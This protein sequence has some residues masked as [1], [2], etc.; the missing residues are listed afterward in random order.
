MLKTDRSKKLK[1]NIWKIFILRITQ[2]RYYF[3]MLS[4]YFLTIP[5][6]N[7]HQIG[8][9]AGIG[10]LSEFLFELP[11]GYL[12]DK[13]G[14]KKMLI[15]AKVFMICGISSF[16]H[17]GSYQFFI[18]GAMFTSLS[19]ASISGSRTAFLHETLVGLN[20]EKEFIKISTKIAAYYALFNASIVTLI[21]YTTRFSLKYPL[22]IGLGL[23]I[24]GLITVLSLT[25]PPKLKIVKIKKNIL[26]LLR[27]AR[28]SN[29]I[30]FA[31]FT[32]SITGF[33]IA[34]KNFTF[35][36]LES[37]G[38]PVMLLGLITGISALLQFFIASN[39]GK[40]ENKINIRKV[41]IF[42]SILFSGSFLLIATLS[43]VILIFIVLVLI[44]AY[45][46]GRRSF[47]DSYLIK[48]HVADKN[49]KAT[50]LSI[51]GQITMF[52]NFIL[53][54]GIGF[55]M[56]ISYQ[57]GFLGM[58]LILLIILS[59]TLPYIIPKASNESPQNSPL[60]PQVKPQT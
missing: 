17:G 23:D 26:Q 31:I 15:L 24:V 59:S 20:Q 34:K 21:L 18:L 4:I 10:Y 36:Y 46:T 49:Y 38:F 3:A 41:F 35:P 7:A 22:Y 56:D 53:V 55:L 52:I 30:P 58:G 14:H 33:A 5:N 19:F 40:Y 16:I 37:L 28:D 25:N 42:D 13:I 57:L 2:K 9:W 11:S 48:N 43:N 50:M 12:S 1:A 44:G 32:G 54:F 51:K 29:F 45:E 6:T 39:L 60:I 27:E 8:I 47:A